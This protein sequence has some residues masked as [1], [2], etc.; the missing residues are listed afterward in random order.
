MI[1]SDTKLS[2]LRWKAD[3]RLEVS[4]EKQLRETAMPLSASLD[5]RQHNRGSAGS[6]EQAYCP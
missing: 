5:L 1:I 4:V 6:P 3:R 2:Q